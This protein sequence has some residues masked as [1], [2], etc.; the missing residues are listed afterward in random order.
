M[1]TGIFDTETIEVAFTKETSKVM[2]KQLLKEIK[3]SDQP[4]NM[5]YIVRAYNDATPDAKEA[6]NDVM[7]SLTGYQLTT[8]VKMFQGGEY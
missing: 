4:I 3:N 7:V 5:S 2:G 6:I 8:L 1:V